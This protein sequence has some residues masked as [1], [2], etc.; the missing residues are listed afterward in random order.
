MFTT[1]QVISKV[2]ETYFI[3]KLITTPKLRDTL[4]PQ[5]VI[6]ILCDGVYE[7]NNLQKKHKS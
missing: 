4:M 2:L 5:M 1:V 7:K 6:L 3:T